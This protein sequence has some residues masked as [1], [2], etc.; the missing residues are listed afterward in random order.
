MGVN[1]VLLASNSNPRI[2]IDWPGTLEYALIDA[3]DIQASHLEERSMIFK[4]VTIVLL[5]SVA[6]FSL[7]QAQSVHEALLCE[8]AETNRV[9]EIVYHED[10]SKGCLPRLLDV[11]QVAIG[12]NGQLYTHGWQ[13]RGCTAGRDYD[14][15]RI[16]RF[17]R[18]QSVEIIDGEFGE[19][20]QSIKVNGWDG[21]IGSNCFI[22]ETICE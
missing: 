22:S 2:V 16:F 8:A 4:H 11:H 10:V 15:E 6:P 18:I 3:S 1:T 12:N 7:A 19:K 20:S 13:T 9:V 21:C 5:A 17:D 14:S